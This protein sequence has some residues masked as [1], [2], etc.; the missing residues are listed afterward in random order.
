MSV[1]TLRYWYE[2]TDVY[3]KGRIKNHI[4]AKML[5]KW[6]K[7]EKTVVSTRG[8]LRLAPKAIQSPQTLMSKSPV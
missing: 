1:L 8:H 3:R 2:S 4:V 5:I 6:L 7:S